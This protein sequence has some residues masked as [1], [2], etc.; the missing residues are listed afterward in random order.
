MTIV[1]TYKDQ[2]SRYQLRELDTG[3]HAI[4]SPDGEGGWY[5]V[6]DDAPADV[7]GFESRCDFLSEELRILIAEA[8]AEF[9]GLS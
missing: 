2:T 9:G 6:E 8:Q 3:G 5:L 1:H 4:F 7:S